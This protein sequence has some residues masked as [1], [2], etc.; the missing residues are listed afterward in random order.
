MYKVRIIVWLL[1]VLTL[2]YGARDADAWQAPA[3]QTQIYAVGKGVSAPTL[4]REVRPGYPAKAKSKRIEGT[5]FMTCVLMPDGTVTEVQITRSIDPVFGLD[6][7][8]IDT[9]RQW[10]FEPGR[11]DGVPVPVAV[12]IEMT[13]SLRYRPSADTQWPEA[14]TAGALATGASIREWAATLTDTST[15]QIDLAYPEAWPL[16]RNPTPGRLL[17]IQG[18]ADRTWYFVVSLVRP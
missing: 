14:F 6:Q 17:D 11:K 1:P 16:R 12:E 18:D 9:L 13:F 10:R 15:P 2:S 3:T 8:A 7:E 4:I 5:V